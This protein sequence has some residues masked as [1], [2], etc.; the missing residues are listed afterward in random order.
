MAPLSSFALKRK[1][2][3]DY[4]PYL[5]GSNG[6]AGWRLGGEMGFMKYPWADFETSH[7]RML[8]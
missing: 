5:L 2:N 1:R 4:T 8:P 6:N 7:Y 3:Q